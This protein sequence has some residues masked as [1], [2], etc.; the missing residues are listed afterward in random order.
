MTTDPTMHKTHP[1]IPI[2]PNFSFK[3]KCA[4]MALATK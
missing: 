1:S 4:R 3:K 2:F